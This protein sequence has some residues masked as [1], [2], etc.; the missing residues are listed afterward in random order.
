VHYRSAAEM[1]SPQARAEKLVPRADWDPSCLRSHPALGAFARSVAPFVSSASWPPVDTWNTALPRPRPRTR[2][3][4]EIVFVPDRKQRRRRTP[5]ALESLYDERIFRLG[6]I[7]SRERCWHDFFN[8]LAW[9]NFPAAKVEL[10]A[11]QRSALLEWVAEGSAR[12]PGA[13]TREQD[14]LALLDE[15]GQ[16]LLVCERETERVEALLRRSD[17]DGLACAVAAGAARF[18]LFGHALAEHLVSSEAT[19][20][21]STLL[22]PIEHAMPLEEDALTALAD[23]TVAARLRAGGV[24][25]PRELVS[26]PLDARLYAARA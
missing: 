6:E 10:N 18:L 23:F 4:R 14:A 21:A 26:L 5:I 16:I 15:G 13:R 11:R 2:G 25:S 19:V 7:P 12:L 20:R 22:L 17:V 1:P 8:F 3:D 24:T 9:I